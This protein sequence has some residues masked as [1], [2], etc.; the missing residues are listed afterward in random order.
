MKPIGD[1]KV[2]RLQPPQGFTLID[3]LPFEI[4]AGRTLFT[5]NDTHL[6]LY[7]HAA[8]KKLWGQVRFNDEF[9][10]PPKHAHGGA[11]AYVLDEAMGTVCWR[12]FKPVVAKSI[13]V[14]FKKMVPLH[15][16]L[17][18]TAEIV[19]EENGDVRVVS[20]LLDAAKHVLARG[21][22]L[23]HVLAY[24]QFEHLLRQSDVDLSLWF[25]EL[26]K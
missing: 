19:G 3:N 14:E 12:N 24:A 8:E 6:N 15:V 10:G 25:P 18:V 13:Q 21:S 7:G 5:Q 16:D 23:F 4:G 2:S 20:E 26:R 1:S 11:Q 9:T 17:A 22:G